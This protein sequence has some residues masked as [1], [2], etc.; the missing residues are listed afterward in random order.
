MFQ[1]VDLK[2]KPRTNG[3]KP[4]LAAC[5]RRFANTWIRTAGCLERLDKT[6][7]S[8]TETREHCNKGDRSESKL[9]SRAMP[10]RLLG[11]NEPKQ[12]IQTLGHAENSDIQSAQHNVRKQS[13]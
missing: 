13:L 6:K 5:G 9:V 8:K 4:G 10:P 3:G 2:E 7:Q 11:S 1:R 12:R